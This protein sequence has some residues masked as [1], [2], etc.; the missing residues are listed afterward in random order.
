MVS[1]IYEHYQDAL[2]LDAIAGSCGFNH[3]SYFSKIFLRNYGC[4]PTQY[5]KL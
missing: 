4:T 2:T 1:F 5:R 3:L